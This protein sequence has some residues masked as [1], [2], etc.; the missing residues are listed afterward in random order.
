MTKQF[1]IQQYIDTII[2]GTITT[3]SLCQATACTLPTVLTFIKNH[4]DRF[5]KVGRGKYLIKA[6]NVTSVSDPEINDPI[7]W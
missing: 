7:A 2:G 5:E 6:N 3:T 4:P 1:A